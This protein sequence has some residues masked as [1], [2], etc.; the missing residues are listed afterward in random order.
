MATWSNYSLLDAV[1]PLMEQLTF[2]HNHTMM[3]IIIIMIMVSYMMITMMMNKFMN[4]TLMENQTMEITWTIIPMIM[5]IFIAM[6]SLNLLYLI[7]EI[8]MPS[9]T[10]KTI[11]HQWYWTYEL[12]DFLKKELECYMMPITKNFQFRLLETD[13]QLVLPLKSKIRMMFTSMDVI[14]SWTIQSMGIK[15]DTT[16]GRLNQMM[17][18]IN[19]PGTY[20]GQCSEICGMNHSFMPTS[21]ES[22]PANKFIKWINSI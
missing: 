16:P 4:K 3:I 8:N 11:G 13:N 17:L 21:I 19:Y 18:F 14:H 2:F 1:S 20:F 22:M 12:T 10:I 6:P 5:L 9:L 15:M 7:D